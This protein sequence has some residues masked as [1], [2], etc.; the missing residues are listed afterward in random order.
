MNISS[1]WKH[2]L[3][4]T[5]SLTSFA[6]L[7]Y[8]LFLRSPQASDTPGGSDVTGDSSHPGWDVCNII[9]LHHIYR[10]DT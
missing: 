2:I 9:G 5:L 10:Y 6:S 7:F 8:V 4:L 3:Y 1:T